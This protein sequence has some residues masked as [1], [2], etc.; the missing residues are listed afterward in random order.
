MYVFEEKMCLVRVYVRDACLRF[1]FKE[2][3]ITHFHF[4]EILD[5][6]DWL[7]AN[8]TSDREF[9]GIYQMVG[10]SPLHLF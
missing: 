7:R 5:V 8:L 9:G 2:L 10:V 6:W 1:Q 3:L 4:W